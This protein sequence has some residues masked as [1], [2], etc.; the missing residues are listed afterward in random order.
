MKG[1]IRPQKMLILIV[2]T[3]LLCLFVRC[4]QQNPEATAEA[5]ARA[6]IELSLQLWNEG[7][8]DL[9]DQVYAPDVVRHDYGANKD[10]VGL[11]GQKE[12]IAENRT[13]F[14]DLILTIDEMIFEGG[15]VAMRWTLSGTNTGPLV[16]TPPT[17]NKMQLRGISIVHTIEGKATE[18]W[19]V[20]NQMDMLQQLGLFPPTP[21]EK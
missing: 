11:D 16:D 1:S 4:Q 7:N 9:A 15:V 19:D 18:I 21:A 13:A 14:P 17:G 3:S 10:I 8:M 2:A 20:Y 12:L 6:A 5:Q